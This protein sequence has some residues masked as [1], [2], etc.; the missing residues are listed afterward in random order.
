MRQT[1][2]RSQ[3]ILTTHGS[4]AA[5]VLKLALKHTDTKIKMAFD[6]V[7]PRARDISTAVAT[8]VKHK[9]HTK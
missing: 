2:K 1:S 3:E 5:Y 8:R 4:R 7:F 6:L 9:G